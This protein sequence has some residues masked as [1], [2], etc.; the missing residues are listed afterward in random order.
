QMRAG[1]EKALSELKEEIAELRKE[2]SPPAERPMTVRQER[3]QQRAQMVA[4]LQQARI[5]DEGDN[6]PVKEKPAYWPIINR[7]TEMLGVTRKT[8]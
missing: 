3:Y 5:Y 4:R 7:L 2:V 6:Q 1:V 8:A